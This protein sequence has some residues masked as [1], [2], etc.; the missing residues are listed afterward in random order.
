MTS[1]FILANTF[2]RVEHTKGVVSE[3]APPPIVHSSAGLEHVGVIVQV[4]GAGEEMWLL[5]GHMLFHQDCMRYQRGELYH[6]DKRGGEEEGRRGEEEGRRGEEKGRRG[7]EEGR[8]GGGGG[9][10]KEEGG[11]GGGGGGKGEGRGGGGGKEEGGGGGGGGGEEDE[12]EEERRRRRRRR[13]R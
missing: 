4:Q 10:G 5:G 2:Y 13:R 3:V 8:R 6:L 12:E 11:G 7:E 9:G 1:H